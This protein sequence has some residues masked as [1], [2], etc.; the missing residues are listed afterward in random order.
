MR[1]G[2]RRRGRLLPEGGVLVFLTSIISADG[3][4]RLTGTFGRRVDALAFARNQ[5]AKGESY[6]IALIEK[7]V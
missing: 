5:T 6:A 2:R 3:F 7:V 1:V 4:I